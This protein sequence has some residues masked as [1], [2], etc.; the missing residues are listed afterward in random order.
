M[1]G[2]SE[3]RERD[4]FGESITNNVFAPAPVV[5]FIDSLALLRGP[6]GLFVGFEQSRAKPRGAEVLTAAGREE[7]KPA[8]F[9]Y[10]LGKGEVIRVGVSGWQAQAVGPEANAN[11]AYTTQ[12]IL[13]E[14]VK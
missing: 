11:V 8:L 14:L 13:Q 2:P 3:R 1:T 6:T 12:R 4:I 10:K 5:P 9:A 7:T